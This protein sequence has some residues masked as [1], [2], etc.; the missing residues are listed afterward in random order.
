MVSQLSALPHPVSALV[1][2]ED[3]QGRQRLCKALKQPRN[4]DLVRARVTT[5]SD[6]DLAASLE[7]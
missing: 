3:S 7:L 2:D 4:G 6:Y 1:V 5:A